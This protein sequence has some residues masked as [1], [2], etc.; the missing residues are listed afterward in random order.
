MTFINA[1]IYT[2]E[3]PDV[4]ENGYITFNN[5]KFTAVGNMADFAKDSDDEICDLQ[6]GI[7]TPGFVESHCHLG[8][9]EDSLGFE[10]DDGNE[11]TDPCTPQLRA[12]D[13]VNVYDKC[14]EDARHAGITTIVTG[15]GSS[16]PIGG[17]IAALKT[18]PGSTDS[19]ILK[20]SLAIK[21]ALGENPKDNYHAKNQSPVTRMATAAIIREQLFVAGKY[22]EDIKKA[23]KSDD[24]DSPEFCMKSEALLIGYPK[25]TEEKKAILDEVIF[26][27]DAVQTAEGKKYIL[28]N[29]PNDKID[30]IIHVLPGMKSPSI[31]PLAQEGWSSLHSVIDEERFWEIIGK[32]KSLGAQGILVIPI[33]K[34][35]V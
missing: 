24:F 25:L 18:L 33:E 27:I 6:G 12:I 5:G 22:N 28:L 19:M 29:A 17:Q 16:N 35:I 21:T 7:I 34:M 1:K 2:C 13:A 14:F 32:L 30:D 23:R 15:P 20:A 10:G 8:M 26:R 4:I 9:W 11:D 31:L 3:N